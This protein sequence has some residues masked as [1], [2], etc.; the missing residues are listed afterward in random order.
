MLCAQV[1]RIIIFFSLGAVW[2][3][4]KQ[5]AAQSAKVALVLQKESLDCV[6]R[7]VV[8]GIGKHLHRHLVATQV[9]AN[10]NHP[11]HILQD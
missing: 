8:H 11:L 5:H 1:L 10:E 2:V 6:R 4:V 3:Q 9:I 7:P